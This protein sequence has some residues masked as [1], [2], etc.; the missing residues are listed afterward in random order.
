MRALISLSAL[1]LLAGCATTG[2]TPGD[3]Y[4]KINRKM[5]SLD[6]S[7][8]KHV[9]TPVAK[10][11]RTVMP[12][13]IRHGL[14]NMLENVSEPFTVINCFLQGKPMR[15]AERLRPLPDQHHDRHR[16]LP[17]CRQQGR[18]QADARRSRPD[19]RGL[20][21]QE[22]QLSRAAAL[23]TLDDPRRHRHARGAVGRPLSASSPAT[24]SSFWPNAGA[25]RVR[26]R[27]CACQPDRQ[28]R[29]HLAGDERGL[30]CGG[31]LRL[32]PASRPLRSPTRTTAVPAARPSDDAA[33]NA[34]LDELGPDNAAAPA[35]NVPAAPAAPT[36]RSAATAAEVSARTCGIASAAQK[37]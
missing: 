12:T 25:H 20:G 10:G 13:P 14:S 15:G 5:W 34:A 26:V 28:R 7:L 17:R 29:G 9:A 27:R 8:D 21:R 18:L 24:I 16:R 32:S 19:L 22:E 31:A 4:E 33:L 1:A 37:G 30:L 36:P 6:Q 23:R 11:Y 2:G 35:S 3:P